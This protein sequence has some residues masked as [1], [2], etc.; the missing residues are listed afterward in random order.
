MKRVI[1]YDPM[2]GITEIFHDDIG[3]DKWAIE[4][5]Q[6]VGPQLE[7]AKDMR[8]D[9]ENTKQG[10]KNGMWHYAH[11]PNMVITKMINE[12]G[13]NPYNPNHATDL[14]KLIDRKY[15]YLKVTDGHHKFH[16]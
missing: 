12:D 3:S 7:A 14:G 9:S 8:N 2:T 15:P 4:T 10:I 5:V 13:I 11:I 1:D 6:N 16:S